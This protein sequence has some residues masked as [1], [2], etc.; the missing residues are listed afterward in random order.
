MEQVLGDIIVVVQIKFYDVY[1]N[2]TYW[3]SSVVDEW[4]SKVVHILKE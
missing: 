2:A 4:L 3:T 1:L